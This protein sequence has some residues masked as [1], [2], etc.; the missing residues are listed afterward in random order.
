MCNLT[1]DEK[2]FIVDAIKG[3]QFSGNVQNLKTAIELIDAIIHKLGSEENEK[4]QN[5]D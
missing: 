1:A 2:K 4:L 3:I 5:S